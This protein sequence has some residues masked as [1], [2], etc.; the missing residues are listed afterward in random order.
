MPMNNGTLCMLYGLS[1]SECKEVM[2]CHYFDYKKAK[3]IKEN[4]M[5]KYAQLQSE[6]FNDEELLNLIDKATTDVFY[7][8]KSETDKSKDT[9]EK[10]I[11]NMFNDLK[12]TAE[13][14]KDTYGVDTNKGLFN[15][16][17][18]IDL[19]AKVLN[20]PVNVLKDVISCAYKKN[21]LNNEIKLQVND[22]TE[23]SLLQYLHYFNSIGMLNKKIFDTLFTVTYS[24]YIVTLQKQIQSV[25]N[26][27]DNELDKLAD[28]IDEYYS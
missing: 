23:I 8:L 28:I 1:E 7:T 6:V 17:L 27:T 15:Q 2:N 16:S 26:L 5:K 25:S 14:I 10:T 24:V 9:S 21:N 4:K 19:V 22:I 11:N 12:E 13:L 18:D 20:I 3:Q